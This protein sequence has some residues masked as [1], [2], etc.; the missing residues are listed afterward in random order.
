MRITIK[1]LIACVAF[2]GL[3]V[4]GLSELTP[5][6]EVVLTLGEPYEQ[7][8]HLSRS[9]L[10]KGEPNMNWAGVLNR[11]ARLRFTD[12]QYGFVTPPSRFFMTMYDER[13]N[14]SGVT[15]SP[16]VKVLPLNESMAILTDLQTQ[17]RHGGWKPFPPGPEAPLDDTKA[18]RDKI[19]NCDAP[20]TRWN[21]GSKFQVALNIRCFRLEDRPNDELYLITLDLTDQWINEDSS[22]KDPSDRRAK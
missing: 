15:L 5:S 1:R 8:R 4:W 11:P 12:P 3:S 14:V 13:G 9:T 7:V 10:P 2:V 21:G 17:L 19:R 20:T 22:I 6:D 18:I 16:Q